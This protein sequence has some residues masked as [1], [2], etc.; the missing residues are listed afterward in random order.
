MTTNAGEEVGTKEPLLLLAGL[1]IVFPSWKAVWMLL[2]TLQIE[3]LYGPAIP[4]TITHSNISTSFNRDTYSSMFITV[5]FTVARKWNQCSCQPTNTFIMKVWQIYTMEIF[6]CKEKWNLQ[7]NGQNW[8]TYKAK[9]LQAG[10]DEYRL[11]SLRCRSQ[12]LTVEYVFLGGSKYG[13]KWGNQR[14]AHE[15]EKRGFKREEW[16]RE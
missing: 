8:R 11:L 5:I 2:K 3:G 16:G 14:G 7:E 12:P 10:E 15:T 9:N 1:W 4:L 6:T 13:W